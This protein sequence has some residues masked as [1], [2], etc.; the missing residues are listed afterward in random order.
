[1]TWYG[2]TSLGPFF[3][4]IT[5]TFSFLTPFSLLSSDVRN[6]VTMKS[7]LKK[8]KT[9]KRKKENENEEI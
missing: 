9:K 3:R 2:T 1:M 7:E 8:A 5:T 6:L 4:S